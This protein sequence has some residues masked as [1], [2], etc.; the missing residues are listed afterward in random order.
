MASLRGCVEKVKLR[1]RTAPATVY[2]RSS[3]RITQATER[4]A[5]FSD[6]RGVLLG[7]DAIDKNQ[8]F[9]TCTAYR[10]FN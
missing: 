9:M 6:L 1:E 8:P 4:A 3:L 5:S 2:R 10:L 7:E